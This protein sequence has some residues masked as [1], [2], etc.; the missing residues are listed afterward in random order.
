MGL[1]DWKKIPSSTLRFSVL[2][3]RA[4]AS[5]V[6]IIQTA[7]SLNR[8][9]YKKGNHSLSKHAFIEIVNTTKLH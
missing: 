3:R 9:Y 4:I 2:Q 8:G 5:V 1:Y 7:V 6:Y